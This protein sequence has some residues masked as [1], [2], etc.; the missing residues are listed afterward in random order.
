[1]IKWFST[2]KN[3]ELLDLTLEITNQCNLRCRCCGIWREPRPMSLSLSIVEYI[4]AALLKKNKLNSV[5]L[6]G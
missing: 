6:T 5:A 2:M 1:M 3:E 4:T